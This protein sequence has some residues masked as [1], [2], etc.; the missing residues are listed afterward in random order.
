MLGC[1]GKAQVVCRL[2]HP[3]FRGLLLVRLSE[4]EVTRYPAIDS[5]A[6]TYFLE[7]LRGGYDPT[8][9][10]SGLAHDRVAM[11]RCFLYGDCS[12][13]VA[14]TVKKECA[15]IRNV[16][17]ADLHQRV[18]ISLLQDMEPDASEQE[19]AART[20]ELLAHHRGERDCRILAEAEAM[21]CQT[22]LTCDDVLTSRL[23][24]MTSVQLLR[25]SQLW[26]S[27]G[28]QAGLSDFAA[29]FRSPAGKRDLVAALVKGQPNQRL[30][31]AATA[32]SSQ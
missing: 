31:P 3:P 12:F 29:A 16:E 24:L 18:P 7:A 32:L 23:R 27:L 25:P 28:V 15:R 5:N 4:A 22:L 14:P 6:L 20:L 26:E 2:R 13:W 8:R 11:V 17:W 19:L 1:R 21:R 10:S 30:Q 9:D